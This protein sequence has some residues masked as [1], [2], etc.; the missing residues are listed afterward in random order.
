[1]PAL[2][3]KVKPVCRSAIKS[4]ARHWQ[5]QDSLRWSTAHVDPSRTQYN[6]V[7]IGSGDVEADI[8]RNIDGICMAR[9]SKAPSKDII[10]AELVI[11]WGKPAFGLEPEV[12]LTVADCQRLQ[13]DPDFCRWKAAA[14]AWLQ[15]NGCIAAILHEDEETPHLHCIMSVRTERKR[16]QKDGKRTRS[17]KTDEVLS[18]KASPYGMPSDLYQLSR[19]QG[20]KRKKMEAQPEYKA[21]LAKYNMGDHYDSSK[22]PLGIFQTRVWEALGKDFGFSRGESASITGKRGLT[23]KQWRQLQADKKL[24]DEIVRYKEENSQRLREIKSQSLQNIGVF[25]N[26]CD[27]LN[28]L[29]GDVAPKLK[30]F[31]NI[32][33]HIKESVERYA[34]KHNLDNQ[35]FQ[36]KLAKKL[37]VAQEKAVEARVAEQKVKQSADGL[38]ADITARISDPFDDLQEVGGLSLMMARKNAAV[39]KAMKDALVHHQ[40]I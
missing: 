27:D 23:V 7:L 11:S 6:E 12:P 40:S 17:K 28:V 16:K 22:T 24:N 29:I 18:Y 25:K 14:V 5:R 36:E 39:K 10:A 20:E 13:N 37:A 3:A 19:A 2:V 21:V 30:S 32:V 34:A 31:G 26:I 1:M 4:T 15:A 9:A 33:K 35:I 38:Q 8:H